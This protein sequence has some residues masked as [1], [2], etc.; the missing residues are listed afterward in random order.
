MPSAYTYADGHRRY[1]AVGEA[2]IGVATTP[3]A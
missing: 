3:S 2:R 1:Q